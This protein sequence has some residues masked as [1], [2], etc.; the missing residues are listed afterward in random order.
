MKEKE[1]TLLILAA[2]MGSRFGGLKQIEPVG[3]NGEFIIDY[4]IYD[5]LESGFT[6]VVFLIKKENYEIFKSTIGSRVE[7]KIKVEYA[8]QEMDRLPEGYT[9]PV[10]RIKPW[11]T[12]HAILCASDKIKGPFAIINADDF[13]GRD[14][15]FKASEF[16]KNNTSDNYC[17]IGYKVEN[18][19]TNSGAVKREV[20][21]ITDGYLTSIIESNV[22]KQNDKIIASPLDG[23]VPFEIDKN[24]YVSMNMIGFTPSIFK[25]IEENFLLFMKENKDNLLKCEYLIPD[26]LEILTLEHKV[27]TRVIPTTAKWE[28]ITY[29]E[30][31]DRV[32]ASIL[33]RINSGEYSS[34]LWK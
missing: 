9:C 20:C 4:S 21:E 30:E 19:L 8:F 14:A 12:A 29:K 32:S 16:L 34:P 23:R 6:K 26:L 22:E 24:T 1:I 25:H 31:K 17:L 3:P 18:T 2:G 13:Y 33:E 28:G 10:E 7:D 11:G 15:F 27:S 5:A